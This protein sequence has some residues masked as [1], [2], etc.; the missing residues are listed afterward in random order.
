VA[1]KPR[2]LDLY[3]GAGGSAVGYANVGY[4]VTAVDVKIRRDLPDRED[5]T[6]LQVDALDVLSDTAYLRTFDAIH[7]SPPC[8]THTRAKHL[9]D[10]QGKGTDKLDLIPQTRAGLEA[11]GVPFV[12]ENVEGAP[13]RHDLTLCGSM[14]PT[15]HVYDDTGRRWLRRHRVFEVGGWKVEDPP[16]CCT[17]VP[18]CSRPSCGHRMAGVRAL[19]VY[20]SKADNIPS[21]GQTARTLGEGRQ[22]MGI[23]WMSWSALIEAIPPAYTEWIGARMLGVLL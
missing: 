14:F 4:D 12:I 8:Q 15:L 9:R 13:L 20:A 16:S 23:D 2:L 5:V 21:G 22:V 17:C 6:F 10:A 18:G 11:A 7:A 3:A 19:G 1:V